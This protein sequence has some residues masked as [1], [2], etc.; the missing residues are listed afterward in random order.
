MDASEA[1]ELQEQHEH[2]AG[3]SSLHPVSFTI[4]VLA[5]V[6]AIVTVMGHRSH[7]DA[8]LY[9]NKATDDWNLYQAHKIRQYDTQLMSDMLAT[10]PIR[11]QAAANKITDGYKSH[12]QKWNQD[13]VEAQ[14]TAKEDEDEVHKAE[15]HA[16]RFDLGEALLEIGLV[17]TSI[18]LLTRQRGYWYFGM[19]FGIAGI[20]AAAL[21]FLH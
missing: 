2:A 20:V 21:G 14:N 13:L 16:D 11:D 8:V 1:Q 12:L 10:L 6:V 15:R 5:V 7:T 4:S 9:Q 3:E 17:I 19:A 18:T